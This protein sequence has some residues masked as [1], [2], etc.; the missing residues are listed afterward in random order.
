MLLIASRHISMVKNLQPI[1]RQTPPPC[2][3]CPFKENAKIN[4]ML[5][6]MSE[7]KRKQVEKII[8]VFVETFR[9]YEK[10][11]REKTEE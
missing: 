2:L 4:T 1:I 8:T 11:L 10:E 9:I 3:N 6:Y 5:S 7:D